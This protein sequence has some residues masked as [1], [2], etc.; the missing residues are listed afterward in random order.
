MIDKTKRPALTT[1]HLKVIAMISM[2]LDH[3]WATVVDGN[4]WMNCVGR[5]AFPIFAF[6]VAEGFY[7]TSN[8]KRYIL[9]VLVFALISEL[10]FNLMCG[11]NI[12]PFHQNVMF[13]FLIALCALTLL[14]RIK[15]QGN[16]KFIRASL[17][18]IG[19][20]FV[21][22]FAF[23]DYGGLGVLTVLMFY[24]SKQT[25]YP[26]A[27]QVVFMVCMNWFMMGGQEIP[28]FGFMFPLQAF[29]LFSLPLIWLYRGEKGYNSRAMQY[30]FYAFYPLHI[31][32]LV[33]IATFR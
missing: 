21:G 31:T 16:G 25:K 10:P 22:T 33:L 26:I 29:A 20:F 28:I 3:A 12:Y 18:L 30:G 8:R 9:R 7:H 17:V 27:I 6:L 24:F 32:I 13:T 4:L 14:D 5:L 11:A 2:L 19:A 23:V 1:A 15:D